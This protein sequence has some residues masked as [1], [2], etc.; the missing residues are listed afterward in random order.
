[1]FDSQFKT[2]GN[3]KSCGGIH[4]RSALH[5]I[6][7]YCR[8]EKVVGV[9]SGVFSVSVISNSNQKVSTTVRTASKNFTPA[10]C[11]GGQ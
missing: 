2:V 7:E 3:L 11:F 9:F 6:F 8:R 1:L 10:E 5:T 4:P